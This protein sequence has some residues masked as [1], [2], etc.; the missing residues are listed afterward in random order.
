MTEDEWNLHVWLLISLSTVVAIGLP[1]ATRRKSATR[2]LLRE[3]VLY[4]RP[5]D[6]MTQ[7][8]VLCAGACGIGLLFAFGGARF[9]VLWGTALIAISILVSSIWYAALYRRT[10]REMENE[11]SRARTTDE[12]EQ[13]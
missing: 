8:V 7:T 10:I 5:G 12:T 11:F 9:P 4:S 2:A 1:V 3:R 13:P 6:V